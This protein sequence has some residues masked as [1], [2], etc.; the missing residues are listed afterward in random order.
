M[1]NEKQKMWK[2]FSLSFG[3]KNKPKKLMISCNKGK[4]ILELWV[5]GE[6]QK[7]I[8]WIFFEKLKN[9]CEIFWFISRFFKA[10]GDQLKKIIIKLSTPQGIS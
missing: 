4:T 6:E 1:F 5:N 7:S 9:I 3:I 10:R 2:N 8:K